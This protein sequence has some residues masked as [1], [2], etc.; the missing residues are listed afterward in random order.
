M[1][2]LFLCSALLLCSWL[3]LQVGASDL[4]SSEL[5]ALRLPRTLA[6]ILLGAAL[7]VAGSL[8]QNLS[9][10][11]LAEPGLLGVNAGAAFGV[12]LGISL[13]A[14]ESALARL[15]WALG[16]A[17]LANALVLLGNVLAQK[18][19]A[20]ANPALRL[21][22]LGVALSASFQGAT[23]CLLLAN[24]NYYDQYRFWLL[25]SLAGITPE[26]LFALAP[27]VLLGLIAALAVVQPLASLALGE[28]GARSLGGSPLLLSAL[29]ASLA[30]LLCGASV[31]LAG[32]IAF[33]GLLAP[34]VTRQV[35]RG[36]R[37]GPRS[38][39][40]CCAAI[41]SLLL[42]L[43]D[44]AARLIAP[45][46]ETPISVVSACLGAPLLMWLAHK[47]AGPTVPN[48]VQA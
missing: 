38:Q 34:H 22:L 17:L 47:Q 32:P 35:M 1:K 24:Q 5:L 20:G 10:N 33:L 25:G 31:A 19:Q 6:A 3:S 43:T 39:L 8:L 28:Q 9:R 48:K 7:A 37:S 40:L 29:A 23:S 2:R 46:F 18:R 13:L 21:I 15:P 30:A 12:V 42:L 16:G 26:M 36:S 41:G 27:C 4:P 14:A 45:P 11:P 44:I